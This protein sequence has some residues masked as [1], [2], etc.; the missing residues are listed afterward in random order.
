MELKEKMKRYARLAVRTGANVQPGQDVLI[1]CAVEN[2]PFCRMVV[3]EAYKA[4]AREVFVRWKDDAISR[5]GF[6][7]MDVSRFAEAEPWQMEVFNQVARSRGAMIS[8]VSG[9]P[10][11]L[12]GVAPE[13]LMAFTRRSRELRREY[14]DVTDKNELQWNVIA[15]PGKA[16]AKTMFEG[17]PAKEAVQLLWEAIFRAVRMDEEKPRRA[18]KKHGE[19][20]HK[21]AEW[22]NEKRFVKLRYTNSLGTDFTVGLAPGHIWQ[23]GGDRTAQGI[24]YFPNMPTEEVFTMPHAD[25]ADGVVCSAMPLSYQGNL[26]RDFTLTFR[27]GKV[28]D[29]SAAEGYEALKA[30][31]ETDEGSLHLG[32]VAL[33][34]YDSPISQSGL[35]FYST[36]FDENASCHLALGACYP[37]TVRGG[38]RMSKEE[39]RSLGGNDSVNHVDFMIGT[40][41]MRIVGIGAD[42]SETVVFE[43]GS[44]ASR[45]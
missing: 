6:D 38:E 30:L 15:A 12:N 4:G 20:L 7:Y 5:M 10:R 23:G 16:W 32:E 18:W 41:D 13:K 26:I 37:N 42:G 31:L 14:D 3:K 9:D 34:P 33:V 11:A 8:I 28:A 44:W 21:R 35:L 43:N 40:A 45:L 17:R 2:A 1:Q 36:L 25:Q 22:L 24:D 29:Y 39:L 27:E 19:K